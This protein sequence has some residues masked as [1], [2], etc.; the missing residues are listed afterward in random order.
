MT[1]SSGGL[2]SFSISSTTSPLRASNGL[3]KHT[4]K[5]CKQNYRWSQQ[6]AQRTE[7]ERAPGDQKEGSNTTITHPQQADSLSL[8]VVTAA[9]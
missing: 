9:T 3:E 1:G 7:Y 6:A 4:Q 2:D 8:A 5:R